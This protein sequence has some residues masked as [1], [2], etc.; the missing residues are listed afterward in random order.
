MLSLLGGVSSLV[1]PTSSNARLNGAHHP[2]YASSSAEAFTLSNAECESIDPA[3]E[4]NHVSCTSTHPTAGSFYAVLGGHEWK[5]FSHA[6]FAE[7][8]LDDH[9]ITLDGDGVIHLAYISKTYVTYGSDPLGAGYEVQAVNYA[10]YSGNEW[11]DQVV[12]SDSTED[13]SWWKESFGSLQLAVETSGHVHLTYVHRIDDG[14]LTD[15]FKHWTFDQENTTNTTIAT[16]PWNGNVLSPTV[17]N[18]DTEN[19]LYFT[20]HD[21]DG[22]ALM[23]KNPG[24]QTWFGTAIETQGEIALPMWSDDRL[25][26]APHASTLAMSGELHLCYYDTVSESLMHARNATSLTDFAADK[27]P[28]D[29]DFTTI[30][31]NQSIETGMLCELEVGPNGDVHLFF[32]HGY[33]T[34]SALL[35]AVLHRGS[36]YLS[37]LYPAQEDCSQNEFSCMFDSLPILSSST[38]YL[39]S[40]EMIFQINFSEDYENLTDYDNDG[41]LNT[42]D[43]HPFNDSEY[44][45]HDMDGIGDNADQDDDGDGVDDADDLFPFDELEQKDSD[46]DGLGD[47]ADLDDDNDGYT[48]D[49]DDFPMDSNEHNDTD[50]D[51]IGNNADLDDD[52][53]GWSDAIELECMSDVLNAA[54]TPPD[55]NVNLVCDLIEN[56]TPEKEVKA[57]SSGNGPLIGG[58]GVLL[59]AILSIVI[60]VLKRAKGEDDDWFEDPEEMDDEMTPF[61]EEPATTEPTSLPRPPASPKH[62]DS[63]EE[64]PEG[65][66]L[67]ND[68]DGTHWYRAHDGTHWHSTDDGYQIWDD[69]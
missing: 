29:W 13:R 51:G 14:S 48:D 12:V 42:N 52:N 18:I 6:N 17:L 59:L 20:Y 40:G 31:T 19:R 11:E 63:W 22:L 25:S 2:E 45:D 53:D 28:L 9:A 58:V 33:E 3:S 68:D 32:S 37:E 54:D 67:E 65:E 49:I 1:D 60:L 8:E 66:W 62:V 69:S 46:G 38:V 57:D 35:H 26:F 10:Q 15:S 7:R 39:L 16:T 44:S 47:N 61:Y 34:E 4:I 23:V 27:T 56:Y 30:T 64:L 55:L 24:V 5:Y 43:S 36:W 41:V 21:N 50:E